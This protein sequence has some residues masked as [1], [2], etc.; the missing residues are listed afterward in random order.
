MVHESPGWLFTTSEELA[1]KVMDLIPEYI[2]KLPP[3]AQ[4]AAHCAW[5]DYGEVIVCDSREEVVKFQTSMLLNILKFSAVIS[6]GG[7]RT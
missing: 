1:L 7:L 5:R 2:N 6:T 4:D 3:T